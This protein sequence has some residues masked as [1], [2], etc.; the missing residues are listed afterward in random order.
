[1]RRGNLF[2]IGLLS[3]I[4]TIISLNLAFGN[5][6]HGFYRDHYGCYDRYDHRYHDSEHHKADS[7]RSNY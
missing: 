7:T 2:F 6:R 5:S 1:M 3:A 4:V